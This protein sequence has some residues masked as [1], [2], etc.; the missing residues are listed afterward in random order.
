VAA[1]GGVGRVLAVDWGQRRCGLAISDPTRLIAQPLT[2]LTRRPKHR[3][4]V[5]AIAALAA[6][7]A[8]TVVVVG[9][10]LTPDG[11]EG[12]AAREARALA[13]A[14]GVRTGLPVVLQ[15]ERLTTAAAQRAARHL[16]VRD[17][18]ARGRIDQMAAVGILQAWLD[19]QPR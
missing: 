2:T 1:D 7:H 12:D 19:R 10:P 5:A 8:A 17:R 4:P 14:I 6:E 3:P 15:D 16:G 11:E 13:D 9:L 18:D